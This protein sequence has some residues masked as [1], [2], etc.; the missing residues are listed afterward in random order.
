M[1]TVLRLTNNSGIR[2]P[3]VSSRSLSLLLSVLAAAWFLMA[4]ARAASFSLPALFTHNMVLQQ[5]ARALDGT[6]I[7]GRADKGERIAVE[8]QGKE[9]RTSVV[10]DGTW[11]VK[12]GKLDI[13]LP[14]SDLIIRNRAK[15]EIA[16]LTNIV[17]GEVWVLGISSPA[18]VEFH[19]V[20][21][22][23]FVAAIQA[24]S[25]QR[26]RVFTLPPGTNATADPP[27]PMEWHV[28]QPEDGRPE[29]RRFSNDA[30][31]LAQGILETGVGFVGI[32]EAQRED[33]AARVSVGAAL[34]RLDS[35]IEQ[36]FVAT[37][38]V[39]PAVRDSAEARERY[40]NAV[41]NLK[42]IGLV[43]NTP[44]PLLQPA[45]QRYSRGRLPGLDFAVRG[46]MW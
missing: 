42:R 25:G 33:V 37:R 9:V 6:C 20:R 43:T 35:T 15:E 4:A 21:L 3:R 7:W 23:R 5:N 28:A 29:A 12:L 45:P 39:W 34:P 44:P 11:R 1:T 14:P 46:C 26:F 36:G 16:R 8:F 40:F 30:A 27:E 41:A 38:L 24:G 32:I 19:P 18:T 2:N 17:V 22:E 10:R 31:Y 13:K